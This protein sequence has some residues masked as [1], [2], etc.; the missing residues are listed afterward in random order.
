MAHVID[1][2]TAIIWGG[3]LLASPILIAAQ[4]QTRRYEIGLLLVTSRG[5]PGADQLLWPFLQGMRELGYTE[6]SNLLIHWAEAEG[7]PQRLP[8][9]AAQL[10]ARKVD[11]IVAGGHEAALA[12]RDVTTEI[13]IVFV[14]ARDP[15]GQGL[16]KSLAKPGG[17][18]T[19]FAGEP[20]GGKWL[21]LLRELAPLASRLAVIHVREDA[22]FVEDVRK[23]APALKFEVLSNELQTDAELEDVLHRL[24]RQRPDGLLVLGGVI[25]YS[26]RQRIL[27]FA[28]TRLLPAIYPLARWADDGGL[29]SYGVNYS[30]NWR[31]TVA[32]ADRIL[33]G[34]RPAELPV[35]L[36]TKL[37]LVINARTAKK[38]GLTI[39]QSVLLRADRVIE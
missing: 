10:A 21:E 30:D 1:R 24:E 31:R 25:A 33:R 23:V 35:Q 7:S 2:R 29:I 16:V 34:T 8:A 38:L 39:P 22:S 28:A 20:L 9:L 5:H 17:N 27:D 15:V 26:R 12:A 11:L 13:P 36:P 32:Y 4:P 18:L 6:R 37:E 14:A 3:A 19:G